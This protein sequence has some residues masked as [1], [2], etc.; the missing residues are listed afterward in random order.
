MFPVMYGKKIQSLTEF[1]MKVD[2][3]RNCNSYKLIND[4]NKYMVLQKELYCF[5]R[6]YKIIQRT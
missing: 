3:V 4:L 5:E 1:Y 6:L 2:N